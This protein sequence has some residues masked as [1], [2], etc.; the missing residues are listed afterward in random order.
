[1]FRRDIGEVDTLNTVL[2]LFTLKNDSLDKAVGIEESH[3]LCLCELCTLALRDDRLING[4]VR[5]TVD[6]DVVSWFLMQGDGK[7]RVMFST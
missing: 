3:V 6:I 1:M 4:R 7:D 2:P 5:C